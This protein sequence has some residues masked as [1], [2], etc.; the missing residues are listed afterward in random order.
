MEH[1]EYNYNDLKICV[2]QEKMISFYFED[3]YS[4]GEAENL[5]KRSIDEHRLVSVG[6]NYNGDLFAMDVFAENGLSC[7]TFYDNDKQKSF[8]YLNSQYIHSSTILDIAGYECPQKIICYEND[9]L[10]EIIM[11]FLKNG[12]MYNLVEWCDE[13]G[14]LISPT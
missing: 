11:Y 1:T 13:N 12:K 7:I 4:L 10:F 2:K 9:Q 8:N 6:V 14:T 5:L 3:K